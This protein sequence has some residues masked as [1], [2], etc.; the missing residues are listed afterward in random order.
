MFFI[1]TISGWNWSCTYAC[2]GSGQ[3]Q[4]APFKRAV[5]DYGSTSREGQNVKNWQVSKPGS[6]V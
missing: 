5:H 1:S 6:G 2:Q 4:G 3:C